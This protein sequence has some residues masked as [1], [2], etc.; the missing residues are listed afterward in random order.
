[1]IRAGVV[2]RPRVIFAIGGLGTGGSERQLVE[3]V[4]Q[5]HGEMLDAVVLTLSDHASAAHGDRLRE[6][7]VPVYSPHRRGSLRVVRAGVILTWAESIVR[8]VRP[9]VIYAWL[10]H[11]ALYLAPIARLHRVPLVVARR[12]VCG[13]TAERFLPARMAIRAAEGSARVVTANSRACLAEARR[14]GIAHRRLVLVHNGHV[15][16]DPL[17]FPQ[18]PPVQIGYLA[19]FRPEKGHSRF[20]R[21]LEQLKSPR[22]WQ[23]NL[24]GQGSLVEAIEGE[25]NSR[26]L[27]GRV[28]LVGPVEDA[29]AFWAAQHIAVLL[30]DSEG[31]PNALIEAAFAGRPIVATAAGGTPEV[32]AP[33]GGFLMRVDDE[34]G[35]SSAIQML[36]EDP[37]LRARLGAGAYAQALERF[38]MKTFVAGHTAAI[39]NA[40][41]I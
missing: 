20:L 22:S 40:L 38:E 16:V 27:L 4:V 21:V 11:A 24:A 13:A 33:N 37:T 29:R 32:V 31:S 39:H 7:H 30:S 19:A 14:R 15:H 35:A 9:D 1:M 6:A 5:T 18:E 36:L 34:R 17:P 10:E 26:G 25:A 28:R 12:N 41:A 23:V 2:R 8:R 3:L